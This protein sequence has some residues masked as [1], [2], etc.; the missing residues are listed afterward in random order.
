MVVRKRAF[1]LV[2]LLVVIAI[3]A[4]LI[5]VL[6]PALRRAKEAGMRISC[7]SNMRAIGQAFIMYTQEN[8]GSFPAPGVDPN[9]PANWIYWAPPQN[10]NPGLNESRIARCIGKN[11]QARMFVCPS[12]DVATHP[13]IATY[14]ISYRYSYTVNGYICR[15]FAAPMKISQVIQPSSKILLIDESGETVDDGCWAPYHFDGSGVT[16]RRNILSNRHDRFKEKKA[17]I[18][19]GDLDKTFGRG[20]VTFADGHCEFIDRKDSFLQK[21]YNPLWNG[22]D[23][24]TLK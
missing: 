12:D 1:T 21:Y 8:K 11:F 19:Y 2:E 20:N 7:A 14:G 9:D 5:A 17:G 22:R 15:W 4:I 24:T 16:D 6:L 23:D 3:I 10:T 13:V 18:V